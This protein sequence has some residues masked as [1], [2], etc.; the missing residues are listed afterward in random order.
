[1]SPQKNITITKP[2]PQQLME[3]ED[4]QW[5]LERPMITLR[6]ESPSVSITTSTVI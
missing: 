6:M 5:I 1:M 3:D 2:A 4:N